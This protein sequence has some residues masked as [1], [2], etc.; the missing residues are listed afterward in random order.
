MTFGTT[1]VYYKM[2]YGPY[3]I[4]LIPYPFYAPSQSY[5]AHPQTAQQVNL[6]VSTKY[7]QMT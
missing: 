5:I 2:I 4:E 1:L 6:S 3:N 7:F